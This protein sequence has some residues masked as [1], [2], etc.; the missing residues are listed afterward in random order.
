MKIV[1]TNSFN[2]YNEGE[3]LQ[4]QVIQENFPNDSIDVLPIRAEKYSRINTLLNTLKLLTSPKLLKRY[5]NADIVISLGGDVFSDEPSIAYT[6]LHTLNLLP[7]II[8][9]KPYVI[10]S[11]T[12]GQFKTPFTKYLAEQT[13]LRANAVTVRDLLSKEYLNTLG[14]YCR[15]FR[16]MVYLKKLDNKDLPCDSIGLVINSSSHIYMGISQEQYIN[17]IVELV[18]YLN[19]VIIILHTRAK[20]D[21]DMKLALDIQKICG[22]DIGSPETIKTCKLIIGF[23]MHPCVTAI[24]YEIPTIVMC[25]SQKYSGIPE[26]DWI[27]KIDIRNKGVEY[28]KY[29][30]INAIK[31]IQQPKNSNEIKSIKENAMGHIETIKNVCRQRELIGAN[32]D[33]YTSRSLLKNVTDISASGGTITSLCLLAIE[34]GMKVLSLYKGKPRLSRTKQQVLECAN[35]DYAVDNHI[36]EYLRILKDNID[37]RIVV[38]GLPCQIRIFKKLFPNNVYIGLF[39]SHRI[40]EE[41]IEYFKKHYKIEIGEFNYKSKEN[42]II[43]L[44]VNDLFFPAKK[45]WSKFFNIFFIPKQ[46]ISCLDQTAEYADISV[47]DAWGMEGVNSGLN[48]V[49]TRS[50]FGNELFNQAKNKYLHTDLIDAFDAIETQLGYIELKNNLLNPK[51]RLYKLIRKVGCYISGKKSLYFIM[52]IWLRIFVKPIK[53]YLYDYN[54]W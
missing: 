1:V 43:G 20:L 40:K 54:L 7:A 9:K 28:V 5:K 45:Y 27:K 11:E 44:R 47:G 52:N 10:C 17:M 18:K 42:G 35:I 33:C 39:C 53:G 8:F 34:N 21:S 15:I 2:Q 37:N 29:G 32:L 19:D 14:L 12:I 13:I 51:L 6:I 38:V 30:I 49:I 41:G 4:L 50:L 26:F 48:V 25:Y 46:C 36:G 3:R 23:K 22:V 31:S 24:S 16:D